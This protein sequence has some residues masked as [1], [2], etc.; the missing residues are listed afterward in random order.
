MNYDCRILEFIEFG[1]LSPA[2]SYVSRPAGDDV[3]GM[4]I[5]KSAEEL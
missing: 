1:R 4:R 3:F 5:R 2:V